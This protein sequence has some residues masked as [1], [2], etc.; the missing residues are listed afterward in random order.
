MNEIKRRDVIKSLGVISLGTFSTSFP[1]K[2]YD[3]YQRQIEEDEVFTDILVIGGGTAGVI[4]A[5]QASRAGCK[6][7]LIENGSQLGGTI[8]TGGVAFPGLFH[9]WGKQIIGGIGWELIRETVA[10]NGDKLPSFSYSP[11]RHWHNQIPVNGALYALLAEE[12]CA[13]AGVDIRY[14]ET[15]AEIKFQNKNWVVKTTGKGTN[16]RIIC[17]QIIDCSGNAFACSLAGFKVLRESETQPGSLLF[18]L[19]GFEFDK[20]DLEKIPNQYHGILRQ[21]MLINQMNENQ[22]E[23]LPYFTPYSLVVVGSADSSTSEMHTIANLKGRTILLQLVR[24]LRSFQGCEKLKIVEM[25]TETAVRETYRID[26]L[27]QITQSD[28][29]S[30]KEFEDSLSYSFYP[31]DLWREGKSI[32]Q[33]YLKEGIVATVPL[34]AL[35]PKGSENFIVA[36]R[37]VS[38]DRMANSGLRVQ[39][40]CMAMG[41]AAG[42]VATLANI[43]KTTPLNVPIKEIRN[44]IEEHGGIIPM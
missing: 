7:T 2:F 24:T 38:S 9:A 32:H 16:K 3:G 13:E 35:I 27:Y 15:P 11:V 19:G 44:L 14:Y 20:L 21:N 28:Y 23:D 42:A 8:T 10:M 41:Q 22:E 40:S 33:E 39:A 5:L 34:R 29:L 17:N 43:K 36:G 6:T 31:I 18:R 37:C 1:E 26:G 25:K 30:G 12:K 4:A